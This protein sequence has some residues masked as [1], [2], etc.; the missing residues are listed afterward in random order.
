MALE[1]KER[2]LGKMM[3]GKIDGIKLP[4]LYKDFTQREKKALIKHNPNNKDFYF[5]TEVSEPAKEN[6]QPQEQKEEE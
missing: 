2:F 3:K 6:I 1:F 5:K 4:K